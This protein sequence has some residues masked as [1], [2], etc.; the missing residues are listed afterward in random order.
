[1]HLLMRGLNHL[2]CAYN[3]RVRE[4]LLIQIREPQPELAGVVVQATFKFYPILYTVI[5][6]LQPL[7]VF[8]QCRLGVRLIIPVS[9]N[10]SITLLNTHQRDQREGYQEKHH[11]HDAAV[12]QHNLLSNRL[13][14]FLHALNPLYLVFYLETV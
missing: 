7:I 12:T 11:Q 13:A 10:H 5:E 2:Q 4:I 1:M 6:Q 14:F 8:R 3:H 9:G